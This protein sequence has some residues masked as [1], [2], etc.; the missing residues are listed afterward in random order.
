MGFCRLVRCLQRK[1]EKKP[2]WSP[3]GATSALFL[4]SASLVLIVFFVSNYALQLGSWMEFANRRGELG[5]KTG[6]VGRKELQ[7]ERLNY[8]LQRLV[9][10]QLTEFKTE[11]FLYFADEHTELC[12]SS[13]PVRVDDGGL[14]VYIQ[15]KGNRFTRTVRP[16]ARKEDGTAMDQVTPVKIVHG[17]ATD[18]PACDFTHRVPAMVFSSGGFTGNA[19][20]E[21]NEIIIP[22]FLTA[23]HLRS[24]VQFVITDYKP[25]WVDKYREILSHMSDYA[26]GNSSGISGVHCFPGAVIGLRYHDNLAIDSGKIPRGL[27]MVDFRRFLWDAYTVKPVNVHDTGKKPALVLISRNSTRRILNEDGMVEMMEEMGFRVIVIRPGKM[28]SLKELAGIIGSCSIM[29]GP[30]G[31][32]LTHELFLPDGAAVVQI[33]PLGLDWASSTYYGDPP[34]RM[35]LKY[36][37]YKIDPEESSLAKT[38]GLDHPV[39]TDIASVFAQGYYAARA[40]YV[41]GQD[42]NIDLARFRKTLTEA[43]QLIRHPQS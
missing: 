35:G 31:A 34:L 42:M 39:I 32:G 25:W 12:I 1:M 17:P 28:S 29:V 36:R 4:L 24:R 11:G 27:S 41:D 33:V 6:D 40:V 7:G 5:A 30:H 8:L 37:A 22:L 13:K 3:L 15:S 2:K 16:Y 23:L 19:Y 26:V 10:D 43:M 21:F 38:Y 14:T 20:H 18:L 9:G